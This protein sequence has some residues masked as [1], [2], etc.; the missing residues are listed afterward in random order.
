MKEKLAS[1]IEVKKLIALM[2]CVTFII[3]SLMGKIDSSNFIQLFS[4]IVAFY[5]G[6]ST[7]KNSGN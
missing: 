6:Q 2:L 3:L 7:A 5:F 4:V 1:L